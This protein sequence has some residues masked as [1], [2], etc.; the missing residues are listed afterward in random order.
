[1]ITGL[2]TEIKKI[3]GS[4]FVRIPPDV[5][6]MLEIDTGQELIMSADGK[7]KEIKISV[8]E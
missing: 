3:G 4:R 1:M 5:L 7:N 6:K 8:G 2:P